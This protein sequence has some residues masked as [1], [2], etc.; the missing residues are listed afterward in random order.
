MGT[1]R[2]HSL[3]LSTCLTPALFAMPSALLM[4][5]MLLLATPALAATTVSTATT[6]P[7]VTSTAGD[8]T[9]ASGGTITVPSGPAITV[10]SANTVTIASGGRLTISPSSNSG[11]ILVNPG[12][13][14]TVANAG[15][16]SVTE[17]YT[18]G[19]QTGTTIAAG[20]I[21]NTT[22]R[23]G[24]AVGN[25]ASG[26]LTN[27][28]TISVKGLNSAGILASGTYT[29]N[30]TNNGAIG[31][32]GDGSIGIS[33]QALTGNLVV[34]GTVGVVG[35]GAQGVVAA[36]N[37]T[38]ALSIQGT[39]SQVTSYTTD[40][41]TTQTLSGA[42]VNA[43]K[44]AV[45]VVGNVTGGI[46]IYAPCS[47]TTVSSVA[48]C[49]S[50]GTATT[51]GSITAVG[52]NPALQI[53]G[54]D[55]ITI[56]G[57]AASID[58]TPYSLA[59][60][61]AITANGTFEGTNAVAVVI[62]GQGGAV[63]LTK[64]IGVTGTISATA[65]NT[66]TANATATAVLIN[67]GSTSTALTNSGT[68]K[69]ALSRTGGTAAY[70]VRDL[71]GTLT[72][73]TNHGIISATLGATSAAIDLS[74]NT[75]GVTVTQSLSAY[76]AALQA[77]E[78]AKSTYSYA[79]RTIYTA[80]VGDILTGS[81]N[82]VIA[83]RSG[84]IFG[85]A[86]LGGGTDQVQL[87]GDGIWVGDLH[88][89]TGTA[90]VSVAGSSILTGA[91][92]LA[93]QPATLTIGGTAAFLGTGI[94]G[95]SQLAVTVNGGSF[96]ASKPATLAVGSLTVNSAGTLYA[97]IDGT[98]GTSSLIQA[99]TATFASGAKVAAT[100]T[101]LA[102]AAGTYKILS[103]GT[104]NGNPVFDATT[105]RL[106]VLF[107]GSIAVT[108]NEL[109]L[110]LARKTATDLGLASA[111]ASG[112]DAI[113]ANAAL[114]ATLG[115]SLLQAADV[116][117]LQGQFDRLLPDHGGGVFDFVT[118]GS[119][120]ATRHLTD[121]SALYDISDVGGWLEPIYFKGSKYAT[122]TAAW[123]T[124]GFGL[125]AGIEKK[126]GIGNVGL[127]LAYFTGKV[128]DGS[129]QQVKAKAF[130]VGAFWRVSKGP[131]YA[132]AKI[133][134][135]RLMAKSTRTFTGAVNGAPLSYVASGKWNGWAI[136]G[137]AGASYKLDLPGNFSLKPMAIVEYYRLR[138]NGYSETGSTV[139]DL[140]VNS[141]TSK[142]LA[143]NTT[144]TAGWSA[145]RSSHDGRPL[146]IEL[147]GGRRN[148]LSGKLGTTTA[149]FAGGSPFAITPDEIKSGWLGEARVLFGGF[150]YTWQLAGSAEQT[151]G[152]TDFSLRASFSL[153][154]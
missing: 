27:T 62:G 1:P 103:A 151:V 142:S 94:T 97:F 134:G 54:A 122:G 147:E 60:D 105:T 130:E 41:N 112:Y 80:M 102:R 119:R 18:V 111:Q 101:S 139:I 78:Q 46:Q 57:T 45:E 47:P 148:R 31:V 37:I 90:T 63:T 140:T 98:T 8:V 83:L 89:G 28:G 135:N 10:N 113:Y 29:G 25:G 65:V 50:T 85:N 133:G 76:Q 7:L 150:D 129:W 39:I 95:G 128:N 40:T 58:G 136:S 137:N 61:G 104:L 107:K 17:N 118:R 154:F 152:K 75:S 16:I 92:F 82:D 138:E 114:N 84:T 22:G 9:V 24:I 125:S 23:Y 43:G 48:S 21:A 146:T 13:A 109:F 26:S 56:G 106:P 108:G 73:L 144:L 14:S 30:I 99:N 86:V 124:N 68:I 51:T 88:F 87:S 127:S 145:G 93:D 2:M 6:T 116:A 96:G 67:A 15:T 19:V 5:S 110:T 72:T 64:G 120:L 42:A 71:S 126:L 117:A 12:I 79:T 3:R 36:G 32:T 77:A 143:A 53:G 115:T 20:P 11:G 74:A 4:P 52:N 70:G 59:V 38:G 141:R 123:D 131:F 34:G 66:A 44:A 132:F 91:L 153:A 121:D 149:S 81:G 33:I 35:S 49:T 100:V 55:P 69:A